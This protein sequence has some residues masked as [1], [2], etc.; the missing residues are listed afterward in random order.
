[1]T[2]SE[3]FEKI[4]RRFS[5]FARVYLVVTEKNARLA[6]HV[7]THATLEI[8]RPGCGGVDA[9]A[10]TRLAAGTAFLVMAAASD[11][12]TRRVRNPLWIG[13]G[14]VGLIILAVE[15]FVESAP[16]PTW[17]LVGS[18]AL[19]FYGVFFGRPL[20]DEDGFHLRPGRIGLFLAAAAM[21][22]TPL[23]FAGIVSSSVPIVELASMPVMVVLYEVMLRARPLTGAAD[24]KGLMA[25]TLLVPT[26]PKASP[27]PVYTADPWVPFMVPLLGG[28][29]LAFFAGNLLVAVLGVGR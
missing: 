24:A 12:R 18:A 15:L 28:F 1:M 25:L 3:R 2:V 23:G 4:L 21:W 8:T 19:L 7:A 26:Y 20:F 5:L 13:L 22:I 17:S 11:I 14:T 16:W 9:F 29:L 6:T 10:A 27:F